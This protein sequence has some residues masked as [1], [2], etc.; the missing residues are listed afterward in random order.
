[1]ALPMRREI[2]PY[3][4]RLQLRGGYWGP[5]AHKASLL[6]Q[7]DDVYALLPVPHPLITMISSQYSEA[8][9]LRYL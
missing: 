2:K 1:M 9:K 5:M 3:N 8:R 4:D 6:Q 7:C